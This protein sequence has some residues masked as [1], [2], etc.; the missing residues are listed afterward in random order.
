MQ[1]KCESIV[2]KKTGENKIAVALGIFI[3]KAY[4][5]LTETS[6][7]KLGNVDDEDPLTIKIGDQE[8]KA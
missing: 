1:N 3:L 7:L 4:H 2:T 8:F 5:G 6:N